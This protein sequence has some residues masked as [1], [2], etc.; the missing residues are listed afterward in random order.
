MNKAM[1]DK[2]KDAV[3]SGP[4]KHCQAPDDLLRST[5]IKGGRMPFGEPEVR[6]LFPVPLLTFELA[7]AD[8]L[9]LR[10]VEEIAA[11]RRVEPGVDKSNRY[12]WHSA[13]DLFARGEPAHAALAGE[14]GA[15]LQ[16]AT[17]QLLPD[18]PAE[19]RLRSEGWINVSPSNAFHAPHDHPGAFW[20]GCYYVQA[21]RH[22]GDLLSGALEF[23]DPRG[24]IGT[25]AL[26]ETPFTRSK[27]TVRPRAGQCY[28]WPAFVKHW[29]HPNRT[30]DERITAAFNGW[31]VRS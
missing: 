3:K 10:L 12:G 16:A 23:I 21:P 22:D 18:L 15:M 25:N 13:L 5:G 1:P 17:R 20:S 4:R 14:L 19:L 2:V 30:D 6:V 9:N 11:R 31:F 24:A 7:D 26:I 28:V 29:V 8:T 27:F